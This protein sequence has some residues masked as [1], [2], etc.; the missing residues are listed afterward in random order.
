MTTKQDS[1]QE[2]RAF[3]NLILEAVQEC[4]CNKEA[5]STD[6][7]LAIKTKTKHISKV[8]PSDCDKCDLFSLTSKTFL[9]SI[10]MLLTI[11]QANTTL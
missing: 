7:V 3:D 9:N 1:T 2:L 10:A 8:C 6:S 11:S 5:Y 4:L